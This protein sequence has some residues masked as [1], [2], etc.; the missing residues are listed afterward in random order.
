MEN[1]ELWIP[2]I[3]K[4]KW[5]D[6]A[7]KVLTVDDNYLNDLVN[8][9][10][11]KGPGWKAAPVCLGHPENDKPKFAVVE[12]LRKKGN[13]VMAKLKD[14]APEFADWVKKGY[15]SWISPS[16]RPDRSLK[17]IAALGAVPPAIPGMATLQESFG[18]AE[19]SEDTE[20]S[21]L[22][23]N[24]SELAGADV[25]YRFSRIQQVFRGLREFLI[26]KFSKETA[27][28]VIQEYHLEDIGREIQSEDQG[29]V[30]NEENKEK[31]KEVI[32]TMPEETKK[33][34]TQG[35]GD[36]GNG[37]AVPA[38]FAERLVTAETTA[39][40]ALKEL[41]E[42]KKEKQKDAAFNFCERLVNEGKLYPKFKEKAAQVIIALQGAAPFDFSENGQTVKIVPAAC[43]QEIMTGM[44]MILPLK[45][46]KDLKKGGGSGDGVDALE[47]EFA[48]G[49]VDDADLQQHRRALAIQAEKKISYE[50]A[51]KMAGGE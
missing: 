17:H 50:A 47:R 36:A 6:S 19:S 16:I 14:V 45:S 15:Y 7:G 38:D 48:E 29:Q 8:N 37:P 46:L 23:F 30:F 34:E 33:T 27:D 32:P 49:G 4:G 22:S 10:N 24:F 44:P 51:L 20:Y 11:E 31:N 9:Y 39:T 42:M 21:T 3:P 5:T 2:V 40:Q 25:N 43:F 41:T 28:N 1:N 18:F 13:L 26:E 12:T 35:P